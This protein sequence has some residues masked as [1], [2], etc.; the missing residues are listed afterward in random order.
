[1]YINSGHLDLLVLVATVSHL[2]WYASS[3]WVIFFRSLIHDG[4]ELSH[5]KSLLGIFLIPALYAFGRLY[6][7]PP[8]RH[9][10]SQLH[11]R[12]LN[13]KKITRFEEA[14]RMRWDTVATKNNMVQMARIV[15]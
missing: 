2:I 6:L 4:V 13:R 3:G 7:K 15:S 1:M 9:M 5:D 8:P 11:H 12:S 14:S 10:T